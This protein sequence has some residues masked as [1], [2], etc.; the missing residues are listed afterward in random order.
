MSKYPYYGTLA[1]LILGGAPM[2]A[3]Q[4]NQRKSNPDSTNP[5]ERVIVTASRI[6]ELTTQRAVN[7]I[8]L[9]REQIQQQNARDLGDILR[10]HA[11]ID[12]GRNG[13]PGQTTSIFMRG[14][15]SDH[16]LVLIDGVRI[17]PGTIGVSAIQNIDPDLVQRIEIVK[18]PRS[19]LYGSDAIGGVINVITRLPETDTNRMNFSVGAG[20]F[21]TLDLSGQ[22]GF[23]TQDSGGS[24]GASWHDTEGFATRADATDDHGHDN[25]SVTGSYWQ[26]FNNHRLEL[27]LWHSA[28]NTEYAGFPATLTLDQ[29]YTNQSLQASLISNINEVWQSRLNVAYIVDDIQQNQPS[30]AGTEDFLITNRLSVDWQNTFTDAYNNRLVAGIYAYDE[31]ADVLSFGSPYEE[32]TNVVEAYTEYGLKGERYD[33]S[34]AARYTDQDDFGSAITWHADATW[35]LNTQWQFTLAAGA[36]YRA[37]D[38]TDRFGFGGNPD[39]V[40]EESLTYELGLRY[41]PSS[42][43]VVELRVFDQQV[44][45]LINFVVTS[46]SPFEGINQNIDET[47]TKGYELSHKYVNNNVR[48]ETDLTRQSPED[49]TTGLTLLRRAEETLTTNAYYQFGK[50]TI[51][52]NVLATGKRPDIDAVTFSRIE[53]PGYVL[54]GLS[55]SYELPRNWLMRA[56]IDNLLDTDYQTASGFNQAKRSYY[57]E[58]TYSL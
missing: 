20:S 9:D 5:I 8:V 52:L 53:S 10:Y 18:G 21:D 4:D 57:L 34:L 42:Q 43:H 44:D 48:I 55:Y 38:A 39:L 37:P 25:I 16:V 26:D 30:F 13:G 27:D 14:S 23:G 2:V 12:I 35:I 51:G 29:D 17:N 45:N 41:R 28:G 6:E 50:N 3:A 19:S 58:F 7:T 46:F 33:V 56:K 24:I 40:T 22:V 11:G 36:G 1:A 32:S 47:R 31:N 49:E 54:A 15:E